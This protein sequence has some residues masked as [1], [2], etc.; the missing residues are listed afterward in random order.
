MSEI[1]GGL[2][3]VITDLKQSYTI[4]IIILVGEA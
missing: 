2:A 4:C 3:S 1:P